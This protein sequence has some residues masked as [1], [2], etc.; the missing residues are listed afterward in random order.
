MEETGVEVTDVRFRAITNDVFPEEGKHYLTVWM[1]GRYSAGEPRVGDPHEMSDVGWFPW[2]QLPTPLF[3]P[4]ENLLEGRC[5][6]D[7]AATPGDSAA[8]R[9]P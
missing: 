9:A 7:T 5:Y 6:P 2:D 4:L 3:L 8:E 1:E